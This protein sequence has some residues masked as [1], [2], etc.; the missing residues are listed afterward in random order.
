MKR[1]A[2]TALTALVLAITL[3]ACSSSDDKKPAANTPPSAPS[4]SNTTPSKAPAA[5]IKGMPPQPDAATQT[6]YIRDLTAIDADIVH[7]KEDKAVR[8]GLNQCNTIYNFPKDKQKQVDLAGQ[9]F[10]SPTH[11]DGFGPTKAAKIRDAVHT[12]LCP[13]Y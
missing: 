3:T 8:R 5:D 6:K 1:T 10:T 9:R 4:S 11:P 12:H 7:G 2:A 13:S